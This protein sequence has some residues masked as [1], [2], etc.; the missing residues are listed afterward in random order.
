MF[1]Y[2]A[3][4]SLVAFSSLAT[5]SSLSCGETNFVIA[6]AT[7]AIDPFFKLT[8]K[9]SSLSKSYQFEIQKDYINIRCEKNSKGVFVILVNH[10]CGGSGCADMGNFGII[11]AQTGE[12]LLEPNQPFK[13]NL[14]KAK[15][16]MGKEI[17]PFACSAESGE[18]CLHSKI[19]LG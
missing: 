8:I 3:C 19:E 13:G 12:M 17:K 7:S 18:V 14:E 9:N 4:F 1:K 6:D 2:I 5:S 11:D 16:I 10:F 15:E